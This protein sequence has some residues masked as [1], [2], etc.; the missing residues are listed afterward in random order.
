MR[1]PKLYERDS[2]LSRKTNP[3]SERERGVK[4]VSEQTYN[5][6]YSANYFTINTTIQAPDQDQAEA[7]ARQ[8]LFEEY[9]IDLDKCG[10]K[11]MEV[12]LV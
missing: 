11:C 6:S 12:E 8:N 2:K 7:W 5:V 10:A 9:G 1:L 3:I 4:Q